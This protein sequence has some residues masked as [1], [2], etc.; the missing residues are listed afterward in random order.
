LVEPGLALALGGVGLTLEEVT[1][2]YAGL[3]DQGQARPLR[4]TEGPRFGSGRLMKPESA[5]KILGILARSPTPEGRAPANLVVGA[6]QI[7]FKTGT[8]YGFRDAWAFGVGSGYAVGVW[9]GRPDGAPMP[10][11]TG[12]DESLPVLFSVFDRLQPVG[13]PAMVNAD[14]EPAAPSQRHLMPRQ[15]ALA[16]IILFPPDGAEVLAP[17]YGPQSRGL[18]LAA[19]GGEPPLTWY[20][21]GAQLPPDRL[22]G[23]II[24]RPNTPGF[25]EVV[26]IDAQGRQARARVRVRD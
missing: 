5:A 7:A 17:G 14:A 13:A 16:P 1:T 15:D 12:R 11:A 4:Y 23:C 2:L 8:S 26:V 6:P 22:S 10:G 19:R 9:V 3:G 18:S 25:H 24:W 20:A 21:E